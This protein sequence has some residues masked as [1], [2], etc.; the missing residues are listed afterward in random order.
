MSKN[1]VANPATTEWASPIFLSPK[2]NGSLPSSVD[3]R[4]L[5][6]VTVRDTS[7]I[8][9]MD[10]FV[11]S[12]GTAKLSSAL[13]ANSGY[14]GIESNEEI[15]N[16]T[17]F[18]TQNGLYRY[19]RMLFCLKN[20]TVTF[21]RTMDNILAPVKWQHAVVSL[22]DVFIFSR[23]PKEHL[24]HVEFVLHLMH[25]ASM[26]LKIL[27][28]FSLSDEID[29]REHIITLGR[30]DAASKRTV[31]DVEL[32]YPTTT[33]EVRSFLGLCDAYHRCGPSF[34]KVLEPLN[35]RSKNSERTQFTVNV[36]E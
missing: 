6:R 34:S 27:K 14:W 11:D 17:S 25:K 29:Y 10:E 5:N 8:P 24:Q 26:T 31:V 12:L 28:C 7:P 30:L 15:T 20:V 3:Y 32:K 21:Q 13:G 1:N 33:S 16:E 18:V 19:M 22:D 35:K 4:N 9:R 2:K 36:D 23:S